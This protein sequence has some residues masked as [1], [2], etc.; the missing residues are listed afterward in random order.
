MGNLRDGTT[1][2]AATDI[3]RSMHKIPG[4]NAVSFVQFDA[5]ALWI[6]EYDLADGEIRPIAPALRGSEDYAWTPDG[7]M[8]MA[9]GTVLTVWNPQGQGAWRVIQGLGEVVPG[10]IS[11]LAV[12]PDGTQLALVVEQPAAP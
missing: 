4:K 8:L 12:S 7:R 5:G 1:K 2:L 3:G 6:K 10:R 11:R 9:Q